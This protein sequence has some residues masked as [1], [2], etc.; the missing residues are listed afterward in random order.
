MWFSGKMRRCHRR[1]PGS[2]PGLRTVL[3]LKL[4]DFVNSTMVHV[5]RILCHYFFTPLCDGFVPA[6]WDSPITSWFNILNLIRS[7]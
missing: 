6:S 5:E 2:I 7:D 3:W 1:A 4:I